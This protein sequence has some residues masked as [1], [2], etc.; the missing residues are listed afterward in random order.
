M[1][2]VTGSAA[3]GYPIASRHDLSTFYQ[4]VFYTLIDVDNMFVLLCVLCW[5]LGKSREKLITKPISN[6]N[7]CLLRLYAIQIFQIK[8]S[9][10][11]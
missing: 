2:R 11:S 7:T 5:R 1:L 9:S 3:R 8:N 6:T 4:Y 10:C